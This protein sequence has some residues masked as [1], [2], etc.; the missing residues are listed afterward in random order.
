M[1]PDVGMYG[2][3]MQ[4][5]AEV[6][7]W[8]ETANNEMEVPLAAW[9]Y[10]AVGVC[11][12]SAEAVTRAKQDVGTVLKMMNV[13]LEGRTFV[14][15]ENVTMA[16]VAMGMPLVEA[17]KTVFDQEYMAQYPNVVRWMMTFINQPIVHKVVGS[18]APKAQAAAKPKAAKADDDEEDDDEPKAPKA[19]NPL[20]DLAPSTMNM[21]EWKRTF[22]NT[23]KLREEAMPWFWQHFD[24]QGYSFWYMKYEKVE[25]EGVIDFVTSNLLNGFLQRIDNSFRK[26]S[27]G[28]FDVVGENKNYDIQGVW[29]YRGQEI[30]QEM[31]EHPSFE[32]HTFKKLDHTK[33]D[34]KKVIEDYWCNFDTVEGKPVYDHKVWK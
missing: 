15:G 24:A 1:R 27:F 8:M 17:I 7:M 31:K 13:H 28:A 29:M 3:S 9:V 25:G 11:S 32:Y 12:A 34:D 10:P 21:D 23:T 4:E 22:S 2:H 18:V 19:K 33:S 6:D 30:P 5:H 16:D 14:V 26:Y 20:D